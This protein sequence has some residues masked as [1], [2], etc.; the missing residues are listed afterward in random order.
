MIHRS[1]ALAYVFVSLA[2]TVAAQPVQPARTQSLAAAAQWAYPLDGGP[3]NGS[4]GLN[5]SYQWW[6]L[7]HLGV[8]GTFGWWRATQS[9]GFHSSGPGG[10]GTDIDSYSKTEF[11]AYSLG[12]NFIGR[13]PMGR[14]ALIAGGGPGVY[15]ET[16]RYDVRFNGQA[17]SGTSSRSHFGVQGVIEVEVKANDAFAVFGG[18]R[19]EVRDT[20]SLDSSCAYPAVGVKMKW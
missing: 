19:V 18:L 15:Q 17:F 2:A 7:E 20:S 11:S 8:E 5:L 6:F 14:A 10:G 4:L 3:L 9:Y 12:V 16:G 13:A 1:V